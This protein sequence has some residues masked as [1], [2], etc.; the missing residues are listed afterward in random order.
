MTTPLLEIRDVTKRCPGVLA[1]DG[2]I[3][4]YTAIQP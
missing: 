4:R 1:L 3:A 2:V